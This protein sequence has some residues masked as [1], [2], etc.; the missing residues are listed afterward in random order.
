LPKVVYFVAS[1]N[2]QTVDIMSWGNDFRSNSWIYCFLIA[3]NVK[4][5]GDLLAILLLSVSAE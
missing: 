2:Q 1:V 4:I 5:F 3:F